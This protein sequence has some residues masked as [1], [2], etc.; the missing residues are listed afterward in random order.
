V[1]Q[2]KVPQV[3]RPTS[4][5]PWLSRTDDRTARAKMLAQGQIVNAAERLLP[6]CNRLSS[7][8]FGDLSMTIHPLIAI[9]SSSQLPKSAFSIPGTKNFC[10]SDK[11][12]SLKATAE[13]RI[14]VALMRRYA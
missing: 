8:A 2:T 1:V 14:N 4:E 6:S 12:S 9:A 11:E 7:C 5:L 10:G 13:R 3:P